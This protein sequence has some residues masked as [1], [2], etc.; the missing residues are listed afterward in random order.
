MIAAPIDDLLD[1]NRSVSALDEIGNDIGRDRHR[2]A[3]RSADCISVG[4]KI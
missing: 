3:V 4:E 2:T 1:E